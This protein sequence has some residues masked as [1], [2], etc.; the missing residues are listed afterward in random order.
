[1][2]K[3]FTKIVSRQVWDL[4]R[5]IGSFSPSRI[6]SVSECAGLDIH[7]QQLDAADAGSALEHMCLLDIDSNPATSR[8]A[9]IICTIGPVTQSV[10]MLKKLMDAGMNIVRLN[11]SHGSHE[12]HG[13]TIA[14][15]RAAAN[16]FDPPRVVAIALDTKGPEIRTGLIGGSGSGEVELKNGNSIIITTKS[17]EYENCSESLLYLDYP[18]IVK[19]MKVGDKIF[20]DDGLISLEVKAIG[21]DTLECVV[22]N[23]GKLGSKKGVNLP[24][25]SV[26][27]PA[28]SEK[29]RA[30]LIFAVEQEVD[31]VFAS[32]IR[33]GAAVKEI[34]NILGKDGA[35]IQIISKIENHEG[36]RRFDEILEASDGI[37]VARGDL[38]IEIPAQKVYV[39][40]KMMHG[41]C[42][43]AGK[44]IICATQM[45]ESMTDKPR[46]TR[47]EI[48]D[49]AGAILDGSDCVML[50]GETAKGKYPIEAV[51]T[52]S[53]T[54][55]EAEACV[56]HKQLFDDLLKETPTPTDSTMTVAIAA[57]A[58]SIKC[59]AAAIVVMT[60][61]GR[62]AHVISAYRPRC[63]I[64][65]VT[66]FDQVARQAHLHRGLYPIYY[67]NA[68]DEC[69]EKDLDN[70]IQAA[71]RYGKELAFVK[72]GD[73][74]IIIH[75]WKKGPGFT[76]TFRLVYA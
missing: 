76:N 25:V 53:N 26:D 12:Y 7:P 16:L 15:A 47:A 8:K 38:G 33:T 5:R 51:T 13:K 35:G 50:S 58:A 29:D 27:L 43:R 73:S 40:Q 74:I 59:Q 57:V 45:L 1:L 20:V 3:F 56:F 30:D 46:P 70:R 17:E 48:T 66:R 54:C 62:S 42:N 65:V 49:V 63:P 22:E 4:Y 32:F 64:I 61:T 71:I 9:G 6:M 36:V 21:G 37:M 44:P 60:T 72:A 2:F 69:W 52:M 67:A 11:F 75:G 14:N 39:A 34:R 41:K 28:V 55:K 10:E 68:R 19:V 18:N 23:G 31:M 24:G